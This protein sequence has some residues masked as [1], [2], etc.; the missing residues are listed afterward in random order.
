MKFTTIVILLV[1]LHINVI[2]QTTHTITLP[3]SGTNRIDVTCAVGDIL[4]FQST[5][6][7]V[8]IKIFRNP[9]P[10]NQLTVTGTSTSYTV[11]ATDTSYSSIVSL[12]PVCTVVGTI[13]ISTSTGITEQV[14]GG[15][16]VSYP[17]PVNNSVTIKGLASGS[18]V[19]IIDVTGKVCKR[20]K[21]PAFSNDLDVADLQ[22]GIYF[23]KTE[24]AISKFI[25]N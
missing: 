10:D 2:A 23:I 16:N 3:S 20:I 11:T 17:N 21:V 15:Q 22:K 13:T 9:T 12:S 14:N 19:E 24:K 1:L 8:A 25:K 5:T 18:N 6:T 7:P 4:L